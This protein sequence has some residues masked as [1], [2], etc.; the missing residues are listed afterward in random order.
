MSKGRPKPKL[1]MYT[2]RERMLYVPC[3][4]DPSGFPQE[5]DPKKTNGGFKVYPANI[6][7]TCHEARTKNGTCS[8][9]CPDNPNKT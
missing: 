2:P 8:E 3:K 6:C 9:F 7:P 1:P 4:C 5:Q